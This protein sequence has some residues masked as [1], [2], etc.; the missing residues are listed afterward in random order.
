MTGPLD[1]IRV[2]SLA[3]NLPGPL[4]AARLAGFGAAVTKIEPPAGDPLRLVAPGWYAELVAGQRV[5]TADVKTAAG[6][7]LL[8]EESARADLLL[9]SMRPSAAA[10]LELP[11][12]VAAHRLAWVEVVGHDGEDA[13]LAG[14]DLTYQAVAG[15]LSPP[16][17]PPVPWVDLLGA[18]RAVSAAFAA[19]RARELGAPA[20]IRVV[21]EATAMDAA[22]ARRH[23]LTGPDGV[24]SGALPGYAVYACAANDF[25]AVAAIEPHF[26]T[27][28]A[29]HVG[30][31]REELT[32]AFAAQSAEHWERLG[33]NLDIPIARVRA[34]GAN[35]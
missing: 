34:W 22:A 3:L 2:L 14:H 28:L 7:R 23:G 27:R 13:E 15:L 8:D 30:G 4:A 20:T 12:I 24:L 19:L 32:A 10:R 21:L 33:R 6:R 29:E 18:E 17:M 5:L 1:G 25:V 35:D 31:T 26:A 9:T 16:A 11:E